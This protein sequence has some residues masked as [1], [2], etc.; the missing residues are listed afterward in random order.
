MLREEHRALD[1]SVGRVVVDRLEPRVEQPEHAVGVAARRRTAGRRRTSRWSGGGTESPASQPSSDR[2]AGSHASRWLSAVVPRARE[3]DDEDRLLHLFVRGLGM[4]VVPVGDP[5]AVGEVA[6]TLALEHARVPS[7][8]SPACVVPDAHTCS[9]P[10]RN[11]GSPKSSSPTSAA[12]SSSMRSTA[13][14]VL[15]SSDTR[16]NVQVSKSPSTSTVRASSSGSAVVGT[17]RNSSAPAAR[18]WSSVCRNASAPKQVAIDA[19]PVADLLAE[20]LQVVVRVR[21]QLLLGVRAERVPDARREVRRF[22]TAGVPPRVADQ[23]E[24]GGHRV[25]ARRRASTRRRRRRPSRGRAR[26]PS[27][28]TTPATSGRA[29][30]LH[31]SAARPDRHPRTAARRVQMRRMRGDLLVHALPAAR[32]R[33]RRWRGSR[34]RARRSRRRSVSRPSEST[35]IDAICLA[36]ATSSWAGRITIVVQSRTRSVSAAAARELTVES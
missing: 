32:E 24:R 35:S 8:L 9:S 23:V 36:T 2:L 11:D 12:T 20:D 28:R 10:S 7:S 5:Q 31:R 19:A 30:R 6:A 18:A 29:A 27:G 21:V 1:G 33:P 22:G 15:A 3:P 13:A 25:L 26:S 16:V 17:S 14:D 4:T 34:A